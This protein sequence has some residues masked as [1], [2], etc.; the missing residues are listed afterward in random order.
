MDRELAAASDQ[1]IRCLDRIGRAQRN[2]WRAGEL[3]ALGLNPIYVRRLEALG[4]LRRV[5]RGRYEVVKPPMVA[6]YHMWKRG[7]R[8]TADDEP[9]ARRPPNP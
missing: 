7:L 3:V 1:D 8:E 4:A 9:G 6:R 2:A 5:R